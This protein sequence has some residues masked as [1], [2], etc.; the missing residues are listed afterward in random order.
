[1]SLSSRETGKALRRERVLSTA[2]ATMRRN[3]VLTTRLQQVAE[4]LDVAHPALYRYFSSSSH[5]VEEVLVWNIEMRIRELEQASGTSALERLLDFFATDLL[6][7]REFKV[8]LSHMSGLP[9]ENRAS[10]A[11]AFG[12]LLDM[13]ADLVHA[14]ISEGSIRPCHPQTIA[15]VLLYD[16]EY[17][18]QI[19]LAAM[20][21]GADPVP[22]V[23]RLVD[24][25]RSGILSDRTSLP[26]PGFV[27]EHGRDLLVS[28]PSVDPQAEQFDRILR[29]ATQHFN[30]QGSEASVPRIAAELGVS[31]SVIY[32]FALDKQDLMFQCLMRA[33][34]AVEMSHRIAR[35]KGRSALDEMLIHRNN[36]Y[37]YHVSE[38]GPF[39]AFR[40]TEF[41]KPQHRRIVGMMNKMVR[42]TSTDRLF[43]AINSGFVRPDIEPPIAQR[44]MGHAIYGLPYWYDKSWP[45]DI[46]EVS[47]EIQ[48]LHYQGLSPENRSM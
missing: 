48:V 33:A 14:G 16:M 31:K 2:S 35:E 7:N 20:H 42:A 24:L 21:V 39:A 19:N 47:R 28:D 38:A 5:M 11:E 43:T 30:R 22:V 45:L 25:L 6:D 13:T 8:R 23:T 36:L 17:F 9:E 3:G 29:I 15:W 10:V 26:E 27:I 1:M 46:H 18:A 12:Q 41:L 37:V 4:Q 40:S 34:H 32:G 44:W